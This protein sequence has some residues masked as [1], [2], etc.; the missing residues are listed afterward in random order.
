MSAIDQLKNGVVIDITGEGYF[1]GFCLEVG[2]GRNGTV[3]I[4]IDDK[5]YNSSD[6]GNGAAGLININYLFW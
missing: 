6:N 3:K 2:S 5:V 4:T 1:S